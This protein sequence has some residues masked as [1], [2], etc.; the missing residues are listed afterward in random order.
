VRH[1]EVVSGV[2]GQGVTRSTVPLAGWTDDAHGF[3]LSDV[4]NRWDL[5][6]RGGEAGGGE[7]DHSEGGIVDE[8]VEQRHGSPCGEEEPE[9]GQEVR[10]E[11]REIGSPLIFERDPALRPGLFLSARR[12]HEVIWV[13]YAPWGGRWRP[14]SRR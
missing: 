1:S 8:D 9:A 14:S 4:P 10:E 13:G 5:G 6:D 3:Q 11:G 7:E 12:S 2:T